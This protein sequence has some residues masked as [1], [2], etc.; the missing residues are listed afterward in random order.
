MMFFVAKVYFVPFTGCL[1]IK[2]LQ[3]AVYCTD[4]RYCHEAKNCVQP[5]I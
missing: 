1:Y 5:E 4:D 2:N 3:P